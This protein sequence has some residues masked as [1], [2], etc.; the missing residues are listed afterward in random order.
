MSLP[1]PERALARL[2][3]A[4]ALGGE[5]R[6]ASAIEETRV[7]G[8][9]P[10]WIEEL[11]LQA[12]VVVGFPRTL[13]AMRAWRAV[14]GE[15]SGVSGTPD[16]GTDYVN[17][18]AW[19]RAG[20]R[21]C[22]AVYGVNYERLREAVRK[23]HPALDAW[24][25]TEGYGRTLSRPGLTLRQ[26]ELCMVAMVATL[27][28]PHQLHSHLRGALNAGATR[29]DVTAVVDAVRGDLSEAARGTLDRTWQ[30]VGA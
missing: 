17:H 9:P 13:V 15:R 22:R 4:V 30:R 29:D 21:T 18:A 14:S 20:E 11:I 24:M 26:R 6:L 10:A 1:P 3:A 27:D 19:T 25:I 5:D 7:A 2:S 23:L 8:T 12:I 28:T 16:A